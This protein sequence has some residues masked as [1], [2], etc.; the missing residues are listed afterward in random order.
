MYYPQPSPYYYHQPPQPPPTAYYHQQQ[1]GGNNTQQDAMFATLTDV[2]AKTTAL[3]SD[4]EAG[5]N[6][7]QKWTNRFPLTKQKFLKYASASKD[8]IIP[9]E[10]CEAF[11]SMLESK[12]EHIKGMI[13]H[14]VNTRRAGSQT[15]DSAFATALYTGEL[16]NTDGNGGSPKGLSI[17]L[18]VPGKKLD[19]KSAMGE[20]EVD[21]RIKTQTLSA[22]QIQSLT[23][24]QAQVPRDGYMLRSTLENH[25]C[26]IAYI[27]GDNSYILDKLSEVFAATNKFKHEFDEMTSDKPDYIASFMHSIDVRVQ[28]FLKSCATAESTD[29]IDYEFLDFSE[30]IQSFVMNKALSTQVPR[31]IQQI[32]TAMKNP[33]AP[34]QQNQAGGGG[35]NKN[36]GGGTK[37]K[38]DE[39][40]LD[41]KS[42]RKKGDGE[43]DGKD[44]K[45]IVYKG[46]KNTSPIDP[47][48]IKKGE[49]FKVFQ[50]HMK[51]VPTFDGNPICLKYHVKGACA[52][53]E[54]CKRADTHTNKF[55]E[56]TK[57]KF[58]AWV[59]LCRADK[60]EEE[61]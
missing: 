28:L 42:K 17:F 37:R 57:E 2:V 29:D 21:L 9:D 19:S 7:K 36:K 20:A 44:G 53:G 34:S 6:E 26:T 38:L 30:E 23:K 58:D 48:W 56:D 33:T 39:D 11:K 25:L 51:S 22:A 32:V 43:G 14:E 54:S 46:A 31:M 10:P 50:R 12:K 24:S 16:L 27:F 52:F 41:A 1:Q 13:Q 40:D 8:K 61:D 15:I 18:S 3:L 49:P 60:Q 45:P 5:G 35:N 55:D 59:K 4:R 47:S